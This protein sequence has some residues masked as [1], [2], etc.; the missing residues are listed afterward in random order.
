VRDL[1]FGLFRQKAVI[2]DVMHQTGRAR[3]TVLDYLSEF[4]REERPASIATWVPDAEYQRIASAARQV[5]TDRLKP[6]FLALGEQVPYDQIRLV[7]THLQ[8]ARPEETP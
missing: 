7:V 6:I 4:I 1:A 5:G 2:E 3:S 8:G